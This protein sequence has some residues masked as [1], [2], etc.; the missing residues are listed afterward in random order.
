MNTA[1]KK[2]I[3]FYQASKNW[4]KQNSSEEVNRHRDKAFE[5]FKA[6][7]FPQKTDE[8]YKYTDISL[9]FAEDLKMGVQTQDIKIDVESIFKCDVLHLDAYLALF[10]KGQFI[11]KEQII[12]NHKEIIVCSF[13]EAA[14]NYPEIFSKYYNTL[15]E[16]DKD[17]TVA[18]NTALAYDGVFVYI[19]KSKQLDK[20][21]QVV[22][23]QIDGQNNNSIQLRNLV[24]A[25]DNTEVKVIFCDDSLSSNK[26]LTNTV[27]EVFVG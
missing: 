7:G 22:N 6:I 17:G 12:N 16:N 19:P 8:A 5:T 21:I 20:P 3:D 23:L 1:N 15:A 13:K 11:T 14:Q 2:Y 9:A 25:E 24:I 26:H 10:A 4:L 27:T 18:I